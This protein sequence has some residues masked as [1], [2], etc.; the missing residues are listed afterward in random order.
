MFE[1]DVALFLSKLLPI[2]V[3][4]LGLTILLGFLS[5]ICALLRYRRLAAVSGVAALV[6]L[7]VCSTPVVASWAYATLEQQYPPRPMAETPEADVAI[8]LGGA[9]GR[10]RHAVRLYAAGKV[11]RIF[12]TAG[13]LPWRPAVKPEA[14]R[15]KDL[16][17]E[18]GVPAEA[19]I[20]AAASRNTYEN[21]LEA[22]QLWAAENLKT[23]LLVTSAGHM[24][25]AMA[26]FRRAGVP[27]IASTALVVVTGARH[28]SIFAWLPDANALVLTSRAAKEWLGYLRFKV[29]GY[30]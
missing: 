10:I 11:K 17:I 27:V 13:N 26:E 9:S 12:V 7:W 29:R 28:T 8:L 1:S 24:P 20:I 30:L 22:K 6:V 19:I 16:L 5:V 18:W 2:F 14:E 4:P 23:A 25:R 21:A 3:Y 15:I